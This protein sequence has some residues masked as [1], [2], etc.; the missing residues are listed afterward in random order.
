L[1]NLTQ[2]CVDYDYASARIHPAGLAMVVRDEG[3]ALDRA[4]YTGLLVS[5]ACSGVGV[6]GVSIDATLGKRPVSVLGSYQQEFQFAVAY[7]IANSGNMGT[8][9]TGPRAARRRAPLERRIWLSSR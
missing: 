8:L 9:R 5:F 3:G 1:L 2:V 7:P 4:S 6:R